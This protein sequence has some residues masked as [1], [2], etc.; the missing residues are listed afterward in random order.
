MIEF[1]GRLSKECKRYFIESSWK[2][3]FIIALMVCIPFMVLS[4]VLSIM[5]DWI[6]ILMLIP[7]A[8]FIF[9]ASLKPGTSIY[10]K[11][12]GKNG[13][14]YDGELL[15][16]I[17]I[18]GDTISA[19]GVQRS[20]TKSIGDIKKVVDMGN[21]YKIYFCFPHKSNIFLCQKDLIVQGTIE[22]FENIMY[23]KLETTS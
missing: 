17:V 12:Y 10:R 5:R 23:E 3:G 21:W 18:E 15:W 9:F 19:E 22:E 11:L 4:I 2:L 7:V 8:M 14:V 6:F 16:H 1:N 13:K 20:E